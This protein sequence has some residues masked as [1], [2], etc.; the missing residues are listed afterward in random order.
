MSQFRSSLPKRGP[1]ILHERHATG[2][3]SP[4]FSNSPNFIVYELKIIS[5]LRLNL[6]FVVYHI[7]LLLLNCSSIFFFKYMYWSFLLDTCYPRHSPILSSDDCDREQNR[8]RHK[9]DIPRHHHHHHH[10]HHHHKHHHHHH[11]KHHR[12]YNVKN[13]LLNWQSGRSKGCWSIGRL[14][15]FCIVCCTGTLCN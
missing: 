8:R 1:I 4:T 13:L 10:S 14:F 3:W 12:Y 11:H 9:E 5:L 7:L 2:S 15:Y 6:I